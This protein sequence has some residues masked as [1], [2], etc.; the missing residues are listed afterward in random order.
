MED[1]EKHWSEEDEV[2]RSNRPLKFL[3]WLMKH[4]PFGFV[5]LCCYPVSFFYVIFAKN[6]RTF[7]RQYQLQLKEYTGGEI[8]KKISPWRQ[9]FAF[10]LCVVEK[11]EGWLNKYNY[12]NLIKHDDDLNTILAQLDRGEG[13]FVIGSHLGN[14]ELL[15]SISSLNTSGIDRHVDVTAIM[16]MDGT[17]QFNNMLKSINQNAKMNLI[18]SKD[19]TP[20]TVEFLQEQ[21]A[22]G[23]LVFVAG[24][25]TSAGTR[26]RTIRKKFLGKEAE[27]PYG[28]FLLASLINAPVYYIF[29]LRDKTVT[30]SNKNHMFIEKSV[31]DFNC[32][33]T[34]RQKRIDEL[35]DEYIGKLEKYIKLYPYQWYNFYDYWN[36]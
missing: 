7:A 15:R 35:C 17:Q 1:N 3:L 13:A 36:N 22:K 11:M 20:D 34:E 12:E 5:H 2:I 24:D 16:E 32:N 6:A 4:M 14:M 9:I 23:G 31:I 19:I 33:R 30:V 28:V 18:A 26:N 27:F 8:P 25:R 21:I 10:S 29:G